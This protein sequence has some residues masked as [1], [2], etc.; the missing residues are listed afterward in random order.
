MGSKQEEKTHIGIVLCKTKTL[1][2]LASYHAKT[3]VTANQCLSIVEACCTIAQNRDVERASQG[4]V[5][6]GFGVVQGAGWGS[7]VPLP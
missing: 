2:R 3:T 1:R 4:V 6:D 5:D 7:C